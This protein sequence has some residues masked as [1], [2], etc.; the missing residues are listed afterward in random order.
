[1]HPCRS[2]GMRALLSR[3][4]VLVVLT[5]I[6]ARAA[7]AADPCAFTCGDL[8]GD[9][10]VGAG[11]FLAF[12]DC[13]GQ[14]PEIVPACVCGDLDGNGVV[15]LHD[16]ALLALVYGRF[17]D[18]LPPDCTGAPG[19]LANLTA[20]RPR[21]GAGYAPFARTAVAEADEESATRG[22]GIRR[23]APGDLDPSGEDDLIEITVR[24][25]PPGAALALR[26]SSAAL[27]VWTTSNKAAG[28]ALGFVDN[29]SDALPL[30]PGQATL[31]LWVEWASA[32][33]GTATL[34]VEPQGL[35]LPKDTLTFHTFRSM[36]VALGGEDQTPT[37]PADPTAGTFA[38]ALE[39]YRA[40][41][42][43]H[44][45]DEDGVA[46]DGAGVAYNDVANAIEHGGVDGIAIFGYSHGG[47]STYSLADRLDVNRAGLGVFE[48]RFTSY[49]DS[50]RNNSDYDVAQELRRPP[51]TLYHLNQYQH[52][53]FFEDLGLDGGPVTNSY[54]PPMGLDVETTAWGAGC[55]H[56]QI[57][58][59]AAVRDLVTAQ[60]QPPVVRDTATGHAGDALDRTPVDFVPDAAVQALIAA[61]DAAAS[62]P[63]QAA[64]IAALRGWRTADEAALVRELVYY[65]S[66]P[67]QAE[68]TLLAGALL[69]E[70]GVSER[71]VVSAGAALLG[72]TDEELRRSARDL[73]G[74]LEQR[75]AGRRPNFSA[76]RELIA[77]ALG[78]GAPPAAALVEYMYQTDPGEALLTLMRAYSLRQPEA[79][80]DVLWAEHV[81][82]DVLWKQ[83]NGFLKADEVDPAAVAELARLARHEAWWARLYVAETMRQHPALRAAP[84][85]EALARDTE[86]LVRQAAGAS[87]AQ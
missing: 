47:G 86:P 84:V 19:V 6:A 49:V 5:L 14:T 42:D 27:A 17:S 26:R 54:P 2:A 3:A 4:G 74:G 51:S 40:G 50:V 48:I 9:A 8:D 1:M 71:T 37:D 67:E 16:L 79:L 20:Y 46:A 57:D 45:Y 52:G 31:T 68:G 38:V 32:V 66:R 73:L 15:D 53:V 25:D 44:M 70:L 60:L 72:A 80:R 23:N 87:G 83:Q 29:R 21:H 36:V 55:T 35:D 12:A 24:V 30:A 43:V 59:F 75:A 62:A 22:P 85:L 58:D 81:V 69:R 39:L 82:A 10:V 18:E 41:Y 65:A 76:Y 64:A 28:T 56:F 78:Q 33:H 34:D 13:L 77:D 61:C 63:E 11:D 7:W